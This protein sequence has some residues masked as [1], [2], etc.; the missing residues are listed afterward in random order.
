MGMSEPP[1]LTDVVQLQL[2]GQDPRHVAAVLDAA[3]TLLARPLSPG[4]I[5]VI[6]PS[7]VINSLIRVI[8]AMRPQARAVVLYS[9]LESLVASIAQKDVE[10]RAWAR[11]LM[12][13]LIRLGQV[14]RFNFS[15]EELYRQ[16]DLQAAAIGWLA[17][18]ASFA[19]LVPNAQVRTLES[20]VL[21]ARPGDVMNALKRHFG[22][23]FDAGE[24]IAG[25]VFQQHS[26]NGTAYTAEQR[27]DAKNERVAIHQREIDMV[28]EWARRVAEF[29]GVPPVL[30]GPLVPDASAPAF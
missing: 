15:E 4:E 18:H 7:N 28:L 24:L 12:W 1:I 3:L 13:K 22:L 27:R 14:S 17:Q 19:E 10:G 16:S 20:E 6:K 26:K 8:L 9:P 23:E 25:P 29:S 30:D 11:E 2:G 21:L 5:N